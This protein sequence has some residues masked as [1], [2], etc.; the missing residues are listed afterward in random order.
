MKEKCGEPTEGWEGCR[1]G[2]REGSQEGIWSRGVV[3]AKQGGEGRANQGPGR[4]A[5]PTPGACDTCITI[6]FKY[7]LRI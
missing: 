6:T 7:R 3:R 2:S 1:E 5:P 4:G